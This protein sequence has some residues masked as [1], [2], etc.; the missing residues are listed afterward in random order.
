MVFF[1]IIDLFVKIFEEDYGYF[2]FVYVFGVVIGELKVMC[3]VVV[4]IIWLFIYRVFFVINFN[5]EF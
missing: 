1:G 5:L 3:E 2:E 4:L